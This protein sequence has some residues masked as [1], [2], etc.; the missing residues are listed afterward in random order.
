METQGNGN[1]TFR[2]IESLA[3]FWDNLPS[4]KQLQLLTID[5]KLLYAR[6]YYVS[7]EQATAAA[8]IVLQDLI[9]RLPLDACCQIIV[10]IRC[11]EVSNT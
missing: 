7:G 6:A 9:V 4:A 2:S 11:T 1:Q 3:A 10:N 5:L 8:R